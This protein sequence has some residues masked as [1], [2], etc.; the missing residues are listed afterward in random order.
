MHSFY[1]MLVLSIFIVSIQYCL[2]LTSPYYYFRFLIAEH[3]KA[4]HNRLAVSEL[5]K[6]THPMRRH[7]INQKVHLVQDILDLYPFLGESD[8]VNLAT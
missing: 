2:I 3:G 4:N 5:M 7:D 1:G 6:N 8:Q